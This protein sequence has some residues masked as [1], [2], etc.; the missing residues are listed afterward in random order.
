MKFIIISPRSR[1]VDAVEYDSLDDA[2]IAA[3]IA[4][5]SVDHGVVRPGLGVAVYE[6]GLFSPP[7]T[8]KYFALGAAMFAGPAVLYGFDESGCTVDADMT[9]MPLTWLPTQLDCEAAFAAGAVV[10]PQI[11]VNGAV[12]WSWPDAGGFAG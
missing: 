2:L 10:R 5:G 9:G 3:G 12:I 11:K 1:Q 8:Q 7:Q 6:F 4:P